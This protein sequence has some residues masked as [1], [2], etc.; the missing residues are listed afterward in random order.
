M[1]FATD[2][3]G[4]IQEM[5][6]DL[7]MTNLENRKLLWDEKKEIHHTPIYEFLEEGA[8]RKCLFDIDIP[9]DIVRE[10]N[11]EKPAVLA[12]L[13][14]EIHRLPN[15][16]EGHRIMSV[17]ETLGDKL[18]Y[19]I[20][21]NFVCS[22]KYNQDLAKVLNEK[23]VKHFNWWNSRYV[24]PQVY[25]R[26]QKFR[27]VYSSH[28]DAN[29]IK[30][31]LEGSISDSLISAW[32]ERLPIYLG[33][34]VPETQ[35][36]NMPEKV[37]YK[38]A[39]LVWLDRLLDLP[40]L[41]N[42]WE[43][44]A[45][46]YNTWLAVGQSIAVVSRGFTN[47]DA[48]L[49]FHKF[50]KFSDKY[51]ENAVAQKYQSAFNDMHKDRWQEISKWVRQY[52]AAIHKQYYPLYNG[53]KKAS[54]KGVQTVNFA[55]YSGE[56]HEHTIGEIFPGNSMQFKIYYHILHSEAIR[57]FWFEQL[58]APV[59]KLLVQM[60]MG[61]PDPATV[62]LAET[63][64]RCREVYGKN[65][66]GFLD[67]YN[68]EEPLNN[69]EFLRFLFEQYGI[70]YVAGTFDNVEEFGSSE[71]AVR[72]LHKKYDDLVIL[73]DQGVFTE[74]DEILDSQ[75]IPLAKEEYED[76]MRRIHRIVRDPPLWT[77][78]KPYYHLLSE[79]YEL[80]KRD[81]KRFQLLLCASSE[82]IL[83]A[84]RQFHFITSPYDDE[85]AGRIIRSLYPFWLVDDN[86]Q[87]SVFDCQSGLYSDDDDVKKGII[88]KFAAFLDFS[89]EK[90]SINYALNTM[91]QK[92]LLNVI[93]ANIDLRMEGIQKYN[94]LYSS[95]EGKLLF[96][97]GY[98]D[99]ED[100]SFCPKAEVD[101]FGFTCR[102]F[103][104]TEILFFDRVLDDFVEP[105]TAEH[106]AITAEIT[107]KMFFNVHG[108]EVGEFW[109]ETLMFIAFG[110]NQ[111]E[112]VEIIGPPNCG[113]S[114]E[115]NF[116]MGSFGTYFTNGKVRWFC[117][118]PGDLGDEEKRN[119]FVVKS[120]TK[121]GIFCS[122]K[123]AR[124]KI[125]NEFIKSHVSGD[126]DTMDARLLGK[127]SL[128]FRPL[129]Q[130]VMYVN[131]APQ[132]TDPTEAALADR[133]Q[134]I[135]TNRE[136]TKFEPKTS[137]QMAR[138]NNVKQWGKRLAYRQMMVQ[139]IIDYR[140][141]WV[142]RGKK[143]RMKPAYLEETQDLT[144]SSEPT[145]MEIFEQLMYGFTFTGNPAHSV[146]Y[147]DIKTFIE[148]RKLDPARHISKVT[149]WL[150]KE[151]IYCLKTG[152]RKKIKGKQVT[153]WCGVNGRNFA[154]MAEEHQILT[155][156]PQWKALITKGGKV[157]GEANAQYQFIDDVTF[158][159]LAMTEAIA[160]KTTAL[161]EGE[162]EIM[163]KWANQNQLVYVSQNNP[164][165]R[166][167]RQRVN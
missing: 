131:S 106:E 19:H 26:T 162:K 31:P 55:E 35:A 113:K 88:S 23:M 110:H 84:E 45:S 135:I 1:K 100:D 44:K 101:V 66:N 21:C 130:L 86:H 126:L 163:Q 112:F 107:Q 11:L 39:Q 8:A 122:E 92:R 54:G 9:G 64:A 102:L 5:E 166:S 37:D 149:A 15:Q 160:Q 56:I 133:R 119:K 158:N 43:A 137:D 156:Y 97:N 16:P 70:Q 147:E 50:S 152:G 24:D 120:A 91:Y 77:T 87:V 145:A 138:D 38:L 58:Q 40:E 22:P 18:S 108:K 95:A 157:I 48:E 159:N 57:S 144:K 59:G 118:V 47:I 7:F 53:T 27:A 129:Y 41:K 42:L 12:K 72:A 142:E 30:I 81:K 148:D 121:R 143:R 161:T 124:L 46:D 98:Y 151:G 10:K 71:E 99:G 94:D 34:S 93:N 141:Q 155:S 63:R 85:I 79:L 167:V 123:C 73:L 69:D 51:E 32:T 109:L 115:M 116:L 90:T 139:I 105:T 128:K 28:R 60:F 164:Y 13:K 89:G 83:I 17:C 154:G 68:G 61:L 127:N 134:Q 140:R 150:H 29:R 80:A 136:F 125:D 74:C 62:K 103:D 65:F 153:V 4:A 6:L 36:R 3:N 52:N 165:E 132:Y 20:V 14:D 76:P 96:R 78:H 75:I 82:H 111:K 146:L 114:S 49:L 67:P 25:G 117:D 33:H 2:K 104:H